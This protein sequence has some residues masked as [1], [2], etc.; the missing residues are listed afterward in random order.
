MNFLSG[1]KKHFVGAG[2]A[3]N[4][5]RIGRL[6]WKFAQQ[7]IRDARE[8]DDAAPVPQFSCKLLTKRCR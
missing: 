6:G 4:V 8:C 7:K 1:T 5:S 3:H 2:T